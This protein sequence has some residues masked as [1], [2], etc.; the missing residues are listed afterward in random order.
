[1]ICIQA[2]NLHLSGVPF[3][4]FILLIPE[5]CAS[6]Y[7]TIRGRTAAPITD[8]TI[9]AE[10]EKVCARAQCACVSVGRRWEGIE[11]RLGV[12]SVLA[13]RKIC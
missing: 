3:Y 9:A 11:Q 5:P 6:E 1:M 4:L 13:T 7:R 8:K 12:G 2:L 10:R